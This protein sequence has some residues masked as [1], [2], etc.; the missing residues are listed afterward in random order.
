ML[1]QAYSIRLFE[2]NVE[3]KVRKYANEKSKSINM[4]GG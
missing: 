3:L 2:G 1:S 4:A